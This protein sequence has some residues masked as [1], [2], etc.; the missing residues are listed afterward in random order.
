MLNVFGDDSQVSCFT[1]GFSFFGKHILRA[2]QSAF[3][4]CI[5][6]LFFVCSLFNFTMR[7]HFL[8]CF[9][10]K[11]L[12]R[13]GPVK[14]GRLKIDV[15]IFT[16]SEF[17][18]LFKRLLKNVFNFT[19]FMWAK[20]WNISQRIHF[21]FSLTLDSFHALSYTQISST[22]IAVCLNS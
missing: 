13:F 19:N 9:S 2:T 21:G 5:F 8:P 17:D 15:K 14:C 12:F 10:I 18:I 20:S 6:H 3:S 16:Q 11:L 7:F 22:N 1:C 4:L